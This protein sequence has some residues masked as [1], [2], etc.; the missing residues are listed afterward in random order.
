MPRQAK[1]A[2]AT[3]VI[4][5]LNR[6]IELRQ[7]IHKGKPRLVVYVFEDT[8]RESVVWLSDSADAR[9]QDILTSLPEVQDSDLTD[10]FKAQLLYDGATGSAA[11]GT[12]T[13][14]AANEV[15]GKDTAVGK[16]AG[17][18]AAGSTAA[19]DDASIHETTHDDADGGEP[20][21]SAAGGN[22][23]SGSGTA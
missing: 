1:P 8:H 13:D 15:L 10:A 22:K 14:A 18:K 7:S 6:S 9:V 23:V 19:A 16:E 3:L 4:A 21:E 12:T 5:R 17:A 2:I 20:A 11:E